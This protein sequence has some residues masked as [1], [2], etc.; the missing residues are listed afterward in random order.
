MCGAAP[1][2]TSVARAW[3]EATGGIIIEG[4]GMTESSPIILGNPISPERRPGTLGI[5][6]P[7][8]EVRLVDPEDASREVAAGEVGELL[9]RGPQVF[10]GYW[11]DPEESA[12]VLEEGGWLRTGDLVRQEEDGFY[13]IADR[14]KELIISGGFNIYPTEVEAA[15]RSMPQVEEVAVVGLPAEAGNESVVAAILP[16]DGQSVTLEQVREWAATTLSHY[17]L[18]RQIAILTEMPRSQI[19]K[20]LRRVGHA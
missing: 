13:V 4:Y 6:Y 16:K 17:A 8:T 18:P 19:G 14:R 15:V 2:P 11:K 3:E 10:S 12:E 20:V 5:P 9:A 7:S 1:N